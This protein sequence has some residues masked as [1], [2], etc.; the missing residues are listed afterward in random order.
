MDFNALS[1]FERETG[2]NLLTNGLA[3][4]D[5]T[6]YRA[7]I[8]ACAVAAEHARTDLP[9]EWCAE[10]LTIDQL[11]QELSHDDFPRLE[12]TLDEL[13]GL[14][15]PAAEGGRSVDPLRPLR[16]LCGICGRLLS[17]ISGSGRGSSGG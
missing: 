13:W 14:S 8:W 4:L 2:R 16:W 7:L 1:L 17:M 12:R 11:G 15:W 6:A 9:V 5:A 3:E 10:Q